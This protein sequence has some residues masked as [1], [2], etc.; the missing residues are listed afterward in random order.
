MVAVTSIA[1]E[2]LLLGGLKVVMSPVP[3]GTP[4]S[5]QA[6]RTA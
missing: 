3:A 4:T 2:S 1:R 5:G 6:E